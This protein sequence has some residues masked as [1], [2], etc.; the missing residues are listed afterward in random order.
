[1]AKEDKPTVKRSRRRLYETPEDAKVVSETNKADSGDRDEEPEEMEAQETYKT[2]EEKKLIQA[3][4]KIRSYS[5]GTA[6]GA[7]IPIP[8][9]NMGAVIGLQIKLVNELARIYG[10]SIEKGKTKSVIISLLTT[11]G[12]HSMATGSLRSLLW[13]VPVIGPAIS[14]LTFPVFSGAVTH[15]IGVIFLTHFK[16]GG[17]LE[18]FNASN[19]AVMYKREFH[20]GKENFKNG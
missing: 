3:T 20:K 7:I 11:V 18:D 1:M 15:A 2:E 8:L 6:G 4:D 12:V 9:L 14:A 5:Y 19:F 10:V 17:S 13:Y 16:A